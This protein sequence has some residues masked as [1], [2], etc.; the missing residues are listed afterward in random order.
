VLLSSPQAS[1]L[2]RGGRHSERERRL[3]R[4]GSKDQIEE[5]AA[6][7]VLQCMSPLVALN[8]RAGSH[9]LCPLL[10]VDRPCH[11]AAVTSY[12]D[13]KRNSGGVDPAA[14]AWRAQDPSRVFRSLDAR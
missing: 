5:D 7:R 3:R 2:G 12:F 13:R 10:K 11:R 1:W 9:R 6:R 4:D 14:D 8:G